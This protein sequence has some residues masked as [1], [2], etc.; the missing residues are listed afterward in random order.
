MPRGYC[1]KCGKNELRLAL[2]DSFM[3]CVSLIIAICHTVELN[4]GSWN[5]KENNVC[6]RSDPTVPQWVV[7]FETS[8]D[9]SLTQG[10]FCSRTDYQFNASDACTMSTGEMVFP[11]SSFQGLEGIIDLEFT[12]LDDSYQTNLTIRYS[13]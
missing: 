2:G 4:T 1:T 10:S 9:N 12:S 5:S 3:L 13:K 11:Q 6:P 7:V 8:T